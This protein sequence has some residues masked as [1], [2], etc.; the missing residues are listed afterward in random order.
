MRVPMGAFLSAEVIERNWIGRLSERDSF[1][2]SSAGRCDPE[3]GVERYERRGVHRQQATC[4][5]MTDHDGLY[6]INAV[7]ADHLGT[8]HEPKLAT[9][10]SCGVQKAPAKTP[11]DS[12][13]GRT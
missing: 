2:S 13:V 4:R 1:S 9:V 3:R 12:P 8:A 11:R 7:R 5:R 10:G 6:A